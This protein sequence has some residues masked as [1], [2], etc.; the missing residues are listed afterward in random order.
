MHYYALAMAK[1]YNIFVVLPRWLVMILSGVIASFV[2]KIMHRN[3]AAEKSMTRE[4]ERVLRSK[5]R[6][7]AA[8]AE[9]KAEREGEEGKKE[10][11]KASGSSP[12]KGKAK[13]RKGG[14]K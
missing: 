12:A 13:S 5:E 9:K 11:V 6:R 10:E 7:A 2:M 3:P 1:I 4:Q 8:A 14:K